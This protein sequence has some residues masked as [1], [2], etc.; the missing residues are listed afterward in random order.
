VENRFQYTADGSVQATAADTAASSSIEILR[1]D[2]PILCELRKAAIEE[3]VLDASLS[4]EEAIELAS[5]I[6]SPDSSGMLPEFCLA[7]AQVSDWYAK[8]LQA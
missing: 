5:S 3:R 4:V 2:Q 7:I 6:S 8:A 1:L